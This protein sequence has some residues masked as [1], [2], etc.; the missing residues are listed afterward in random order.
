MRSAPYFAWAFAIAVPSN[1]ERGDSM[2]NTGRTVSRHLRGALGVLTL[3]FAGIGVF[4]GIA[5]A[6]TT[7]TVNPQ[8]G[9]SDGQSVTV[10]GTEVGTNLV[11]V[12]ECG[13]ADSNGTPLPGTVPTPADC[14]GC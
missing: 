2:R 4:A 10:T 13:N 1:Y 14:F 12:L 7:I 8:T 3:A 5:Q 6:Q 9:L 11:A